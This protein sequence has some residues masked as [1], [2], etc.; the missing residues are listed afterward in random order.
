MAQGGLPN[1]TMD[2]SNP[3]RSAALACFK[4]TCNYWFNA[5]QTP[6]VRQY[7]HIF[8]WSGAEGI[9]LSNTWGL[10][11]A[12]LQDPDNIWNKFAESQPQENF[13]I[14]RLEFQKLSQNDDESV[15]DFV[16]RCKAKLVKCK[17]A[18]QAI[19]DDRL[20]EQIIAG[21]KY[22]EVQ[23]KLLQK[24]D[25]LTL[26]QAY[27]ICRTHEASVTHMQKMSTQ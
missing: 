13:R 19:R 11:D 26:K 1:P 6:R 21:I 15:D 25:T 18:T 5:Q 2:W 3:D 20:V 10:S 22:T 4:Q 7:S 17:F 16:T 12:E 24:D 8:L 9:A 27:D 23:R 14:H